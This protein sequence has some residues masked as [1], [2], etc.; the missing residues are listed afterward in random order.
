MLNIRNGIFETNSSSTHSLVVSLI[1]IDGLE[2]PSTVEIESGHFPLDN[3]VHGCY[4]YFKEKG[5]EK[6]F[7]GC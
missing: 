7:F 3:N 6:Q 1:Q 2:I 4:T 5:R